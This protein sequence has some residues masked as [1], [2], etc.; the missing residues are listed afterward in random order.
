MTSKIDNSQ[1]HVRVVFLGGL[2][3]IGRN[4]AAIE[5]GDEILIIDC[6]LM[7]PTH[8]TPGVDLILPDFSYLLENKDK[9][10]GVVIT[11]GHEDHIGAL[12]FLLREMSLDIYGSQLALSLASS[13]IE[14]AGLGAKARMHYVSDREVRDIGSFVVEFIPVTHS[15]PDSF[16]LAI[17][18]SIGTIVHSGDFKI[19]LTPVD[20]RL[21]DLARLGQIASSEGIA[22]L[23]A[24]S[25]NAEESGHSDSESEVGPVLGQLFATNKTK[26]IVVTCFASHIH[27]MQQIANAAL[28]AGRMIFPLGRSMGKNIALARSIG[29]LN[30]PEASLAD[31]EKVNSYPDDR[32]CV[33]STGSQ[34]EAMSALTLMAANENKFL[35]LNQNDLVI[36]SADVIPG[37][38]SAVGKVIDGL[39]RRGADVVHAGIAKVHTSGH[40]KRQELRLLQTI[41]KPRFFVPV[42]G[43]FR[44]LNSHSRL[45]NEMGVPKDNIIVCLD[46]DVLRLDRESLTRDGKVPASYLYVDGV[47]DGLSKGVLRDRKTLASEGVVV[48]V[49]SVDVASATIITGPE[50]VTRGWA[51]SDNDRP[52]SIAELIEDLKAAIRATITTTIGEAGSDYDTVSRHIRTTTA[53]LIEKRTKMRPMVIPVLTEI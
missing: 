34:G 53:K 9:V 32:I 43:E 12:Q 37:N 17:R 4:C 7:F 5:M 45:A 39:H 38:E 33:I 26:R 15:V 18:T 19:D 14:E 2:G 31:I 25:T 35:K 30:I 28:E 24:D 6:G 52:D 3:E 21:P 8:D 48:V 29:L 20:G 23:L 13:R 11:H 44:H 47:V 10:I 42:H 27:R 1:D 50:I 41:C 40:A 46:G 22:L 36:I 49:V 51:H 16:A